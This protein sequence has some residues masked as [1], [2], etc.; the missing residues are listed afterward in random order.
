MNQDKNPF[1]LLGGILLIILGIIS[2]IFSFRAFGGN[3]YVIYGMIGLGVVLLGTA[4]L[5]R[6]HGSVGLVMAGIWLILMA[7]FNIYHLRFVYDNIILA[8]LPILAGI[9]L[10]FGI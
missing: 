9:L 10:I 4:L 8:F 1:L 2:M 6:S 5:S 3:A 7:L